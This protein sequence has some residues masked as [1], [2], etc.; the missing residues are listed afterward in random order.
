ML[1]IQVDEQPET[2][3]LRGRQ[4]GRRLGGRIAKD[5]D[6]RADGI[7]RKTSYRRAIVRH[8]SRQAWPQHSRGTQLSGAELI[9]RS[10]IEQITGSSVI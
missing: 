4:A 8:V 6:D 7:T 9:V 3:I 2:T 5:L 1:R 10:L